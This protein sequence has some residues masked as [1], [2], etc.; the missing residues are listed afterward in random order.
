[1]PSLYLLTLGCPKNRVDSEIMLGGFAKNGYRLVQDP[2]QADVIVVNTCSFIGPAK[3]ESVDAILELGRYKDPAARRCET[4]V[5]TGCL[6]QRYRL[7]PR[8][9]TWSAPP[10]TPSYPTCWPRGRRRGRCS[11]IR[12]T[13]TTPPRRASTRSPRTRP[14]SRS[15]RAATTSASSASS[16]SSAARSAA[17]RWRTWCGRRATS[18]RA[19]RSS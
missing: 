10:P 4:H 13:S 18:S 14:T 19:A 6:G 9:I 7:G 5:V 2:A 16:P 3:E 1:M 11:P 17:A 15:A 8:S 12:T